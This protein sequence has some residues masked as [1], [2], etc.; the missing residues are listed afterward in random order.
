MWW[1]LLFPICLATLFNVAFGSLVSDEQFKAIPVAVVLDS[2]ATTDNTDTK[3]PFHEIID[4][5]GEAGKNQFLDVTYAPK[6]EALTLLKDK[7]ITGILYEGI[8]V[9]LSVSAEMSNMKLEQSIL[10]SFVEQ[11]NMQYHAIEEIAK[12]HPEKLPAVIAEMGKEVSYNN[13]Y[14]YSDAN[15]NPVVAYFYNLLAM[16]CLFASSGGIYV[17]IKNQANLSALGARKGI[18][19]AH[20]FISLLSQLCATTI[21]QIFCS[22]VGLLY[23][24]CFLHVDFGN[25]LGYV[26]LTIL[27]GCVT[28]ISYGFFIGCFGHM[29]E[30]TKNGIQMGATMLC[31]FF[32]GLMVGNIRI[33]VQEY[34]PIFNKINPAA[35][36]SDSF[37]SLLVYQTHNR[38]WQ[39]SLTL[40][41]ISAIFFVGGFFMVRREKYAA[42]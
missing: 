16:V 2:E 24:I 32:S 23:I 5:L 27:I 26:I 13:E 30:N 17:A 42:L 20:K 9:S 37:Y 12:T 4:S 38:Y 6:E 15:K 33:L 3:S 40:L 25:Q 28:G 29:S 18:S 36:I 22:V 1:N 34:C 35:L 7:K 10:N 8:P 21:S 41:V 19:P 14:S 31:S 11:Y 39:N